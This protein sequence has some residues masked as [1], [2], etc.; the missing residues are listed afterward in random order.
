MARYTSAY[1]ALVVSLEEVK[2]LYTK[3]ATLERRDPIVHKK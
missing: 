2:V 1:S 3:A